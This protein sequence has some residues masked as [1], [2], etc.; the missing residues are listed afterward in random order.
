MAGSKKAT[1]TPAASSQPQPSARQEVR[2]LRGELEDL[3]AAAEAD[4]AAPSPAPGVVDAAIFDSGDHDRESLAREALRRALAQEQAAHR[5]TAAGVDSVRLEAEEA[6]AHFQVALATERAETVR[7]RSLVRKLSVASSGETVVDDYERQ[8]EKLKKRNARLQRRN[9]QL[10]LARRSSTTTKPTPLLRV[11][12]RQ[13]KE[14]KRLETE[15]DVLKKKNRKLPLALRI[16]KSQTSVATRR[17]NE[18]ENC[19][20]QLADER[21]RA[22]AL[23]GRNELLEAEL[24][25]CESDIRD[26]SSDRAALVAKLGQLRDFVNALPAARFADYQQDEPK[27]GGVPPPPRRRNFAAP[28]PPRPPVGPPPCDEARV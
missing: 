17:T 4:D 24:R 1:P 26:L 14:L 9:V 25:L 11:A 23:Q 20:K 19:N 18:V 28:G 22:A 6:R 13:A 8:L 10:E 21:L 15:N 16:A 27:R 5:R 3:L 7:L 2:Q 12:K